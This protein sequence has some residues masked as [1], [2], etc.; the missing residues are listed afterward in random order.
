MI[1]GLIALL[2][3]ALGCALIYAASRSV[4]FGWYCLLVANLLYV[5]LGSNQVMVGG[6]HL[7]V[8]DVASMVLLAAGA[9]RFFHRISLP[10]NARIVSLVYLLVFGFSLLRGIVAFGV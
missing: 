2:G 5:A 3:A 1:V 6:F 9:I 8:V 10:G 7:D 4:V